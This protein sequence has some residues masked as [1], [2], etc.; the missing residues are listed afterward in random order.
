MFFLSQ[1]GTSYLPVLCFPYTLKDLGCYVIFL[2]QP[3]VFKESQI[4]L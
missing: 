4:A 3:H 1:E 2:C